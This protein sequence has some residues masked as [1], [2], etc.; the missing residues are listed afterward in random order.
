MPQLERLLTVGSN[1]WWARTGR[2]GRVARERQSARQVC[3]SAN[4]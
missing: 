2:P 4:V 1:W 3:G